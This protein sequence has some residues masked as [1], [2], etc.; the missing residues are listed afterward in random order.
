M[1]SSTIDHAGIKVADYQASKQFFLAALGPLGYKMG[2]EI[3]VG[4]GIF[5]CGLS[6][7]SNKPDFWL[8]PGEQPTTGLH[9][10]F[11]AS[12]RAAV[13]KFYEEALKAGAKDNGAPGLRPQY[14][15]TYYG[16]FVLDSHGNNI[17]AVTH[18]SDSS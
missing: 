3:E 15:P 13:D 8:S 6:G 4:P 7:P 12:S 17:E 11:T 9:L 1:A 14:H 16:A 2:M 5:I 10:A 18:T